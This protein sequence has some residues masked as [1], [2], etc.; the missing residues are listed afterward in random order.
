MNNLVISI[1]GF[2]IC[3]LSFLYYIFLKQKLKRERNKREKE[4]EFINELSELFI[5]YNIKFSSGG[6]TADIINLCKKYNKNFNSDFA[7]GAQTVFDM[8][9]WRMQNIIK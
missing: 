9:I 3:F 1:F 6:G 7:R 4:R 8:I 5:K 2:F